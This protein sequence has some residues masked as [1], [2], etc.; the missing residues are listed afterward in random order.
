MIV[1]ADTPTND[2]AL[3]DLS[4]V[5]VSAIGDILSSPL[6][7]FRSSS[8]NVSP[9]SSALLSRL[10]TTLSS[11]DLSVTVP[12]HS[13]FSVLG[14]TVYADT[15]SGKFSLGMPAVA[16]SLENAVGLSIAIAIGIVI[17]AICYLFLLPAQE[18]R[19]HRT[20]L[21]GSILCIIIGILPYALID[22]IGIQNTAVRFSIV[23]PFV[24]YLFRTLEAMTGFVPKGRDASFRLYCIYF[25]AP[26]ELLYD[27]KTQKL[28]QAT[29]VDMIQ[30]CFDLV[31]CIMSITLL[32]SVFS[33]SGYQPFGESNAG[34]FFEGV[35]VGDVLDIR[36][37]GNNFVMAF[38]FQSGLALGFSMIG[39]TVQMM[40]G[41]K[42]L[43]AMRN[44]LLEATGVADFW[45]R[46]WNLLI[47]HVLKR[48]VYKPVRKYASALTASL[49]VFIAS[50]LFHEWMVH[51]AFLYKRENT[52]GVVS[53]SNTA[54]FVWNFVIIA[55]E[56]M[57]ASTTAVKS[58]GR[59]MPQ[60]MI[61]F[62]VIMCAL[63]FA[64]WFGWPYLRANFFSDYEA[65]VPVLRHVQ[66]DIIC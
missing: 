38:F 4:A 5:S 45:G 36:H 44:P 53:G 24:V 10:Q 12:A 15:F 6:S 3:P 33:P 25:A 58:L 46:R 16:E 13:E 66:I 62:F 41:Y 27:D 42:V 55:C 11:L 1:M 56:R 54:F 37:L 59:V 20:L 50:G 22:S 17:A 47:H 18:Q 61:T 40:T 52:E 43:K 29:K 51:A 8:C 21:I 30:S 32:C 26:A 64:H 49:A 19:P 2:F 34:E 9:K 65:L 28:I 60:F 31:K 63:P 7:L 14:Y 39:H 48:G 35:V 57:L 23:C